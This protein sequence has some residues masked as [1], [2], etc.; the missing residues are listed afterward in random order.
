[1]GTIAILVKEKGKILQSKKPPVK[2]GGV[3]TKNQAVLQLYQLSYCIIIFCGTTVTA[4]FLGNT[5]CKI[6]FSYFA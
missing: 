4:T 6:P 2:T 3:L 1:M 5:I